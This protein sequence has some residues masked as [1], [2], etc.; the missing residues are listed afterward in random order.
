MNMRS[1]LFSPTN[2]KMK[3]AGGVDEG[4]QKCS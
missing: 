4:V 3:Y 1:D 2:K